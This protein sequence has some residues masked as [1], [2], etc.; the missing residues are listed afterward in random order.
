DRIGLIELLSQTGQPNQMVPLLLGWLASAKSDSLRGALLLALQAFPDSRIPSSVL[1]TYP[2]MSPGLRSRAQ[3]LLCSRPASALEFLKAVDAGK[4]NAKEVPVDQLQRIVVFKDD[5]LSK[6]VENDWGKVGPAAAGE[7]AARIRAV[8]HLIRVRQGDPA[9]G[10]PLFTKHCA[11][12]HTLHGEGAKIGPDLN[13]VDRKDLDFLVKNIIDPSAVIRPE[14]VAQAITTTDGRVL[15]GLVLES[16][17]GTVTS[18]NRKPR[19]PALPPPKIH[20]MNPSP[21]SIMPEKLLD[22]LDEPDTR[23]LFA[24]LQSDGPAKPSPPPP[25]GERVRVRGS[26]PLNICLVS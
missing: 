17:A 24:Y 3:G 20:E 10:K 26:A 5:R 8:A 11:N 6:L 21:V 4:I 18:A 22:P 14:F 25:L 23:D 19:K 12:C 1:A 13:S 15:N 2:K 9:R 16:T 7:K